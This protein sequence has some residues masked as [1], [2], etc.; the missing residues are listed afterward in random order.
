MVGKNPFRT[1]NRSF[2]LGR[3]RRDRMEKI[4][5]W[6]YAHSYTVW[7]FFGL[8]WVWFTFAAAFGSAPRLAWV[9][10]M[11]AFLQLYRGWEIY[12]SHKLIDKLKKDMRDEDETK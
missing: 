9:C 5:D 10:A 4:G 3:E 7:V 2:Q 8:I 11:V 1:D 12:K 6:W